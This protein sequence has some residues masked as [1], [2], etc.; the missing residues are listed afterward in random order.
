MVKTDY[1]YHLKVTE[2]MIGDWFT[3]NDYIHKERNPQVQITS[4]NKDVVLYMYFPIFVT[5]EILIE[6]GFEKSTAPILKNTEYRSKDG[7]VVITNGKEFQ[8]DE[9][10]WYVHIDSEDMDTV[11]NGIFTYLHQLQNILNANNYEQQF[12]LN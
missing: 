9:T 7:R 11:G 5:P 10:I 12:K 4:I 8:M 2:I 3:R 1:N 6:N